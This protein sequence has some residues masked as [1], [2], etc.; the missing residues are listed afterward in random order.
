MLLTS[1]GLVALGQQACA[2]SAKTQLTA[3]HDP[4]AMEVANGRHDLRRVQACNGFIEDTLPVQVEEKV[5]AVDE[6]QH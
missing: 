3:M 6:L 1:T 5:A 2:L 4:N